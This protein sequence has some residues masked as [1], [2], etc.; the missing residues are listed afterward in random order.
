MT[1]AHAPGKIILVGEHAV[2]YGRPAL[3]LPVWETTA[4]ATI[5]AGA[6]GSGCRLQAPQTGLSFRLA[7]ADK[8]EP[9]AVS[10]RTALA[11][12]GGSV[13]PDWQIRAVSDIP[14]AGGLGS[15]AAIAAAIVRA[16]FAHLGRTVDAET[17]SRLVLKSER[18]YHGTPSGIDNTVI[19]YGVP[20]WFVQDKTPEQVVPGRTFT[21][22]I[23]DSGIASPTR[24]TVA[25]V[26]GR[27]RVSRRAYARYF[28]AM[29]E[30]AA[31]ARVALE[32]G[33]PVELGRL[34]N[35]NQER[36]AQIGVSSPA[37][38]RLIQA[39]ERAGAYGAKLSGGGRGGNVI[40]LIDGAK[41][42]EMR[43]AWLAAGARRVIVTELTPG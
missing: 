24:E 29:A 16:V 10:V 19:A 11:A 25:E 26:R 31:A 13:D 27:W 15:G 7:H 23:A 1:T 22:A 39:A 14:I 43:C 32:T 35:A 12:A 18:L 40:A 33:D 4:A 8:D 38:E 6:A 41:T 37:L 34:L 5:T 20:I 30:I 21:L 28:D 36:L 9:L 42:E 2:V 17:V 3:A